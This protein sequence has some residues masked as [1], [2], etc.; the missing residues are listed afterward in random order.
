MLCD[1]FL[2]PLGKP[3][4]ASVM[5]IKFLGLNPQTAAQG[6]GQ[7]TH[8]KSNISGTKCWIDLKPVCNFKFFNCL[9]NYLNKIINMDLE[10]LFL[11]RVPSNQ[12]RRVHFRVRLRVRLGVHEGSGGS[13]GSYYITRIFEKLLPIVKKA[14]K[15]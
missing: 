12:Y 2:D 9:E 5:G 10:G 13:L 7:F 6:G 15:M 14:Y 1:S 4:C 8:R 3:I 11:A